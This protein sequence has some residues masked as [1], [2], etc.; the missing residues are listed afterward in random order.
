QQLAGGI[1]EL[2]DAIGYLEAQDAGRFVQALRVLGELED[3]A[4]ISALALE[5]S[6][7]IMQ[8]V[9]EHVDLG[10]RPFDERTVH[11]DMA[12]ELIE[13]NGCHFNLPRAAA[14]ISFV[15]HTKPL[16]GG[17][18]A[19]NVGPSPREGKRAGKLRKG[20]FPLPFRSQ[21]VEKP[22]ENYNR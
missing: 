19:V 21:S 17:V 2:F 6:A 5:D 1:I 10:V 4:A 16:D 20:G 11:P 7:R 15:I 8:A 9:S 12:V 22:E 13:G 14:R 3:L 18:S